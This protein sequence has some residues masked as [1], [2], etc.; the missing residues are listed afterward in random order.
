MTES[1][2]TQAIA[3]NTAKVNALIA[4]N[5]ELDALITN[6]S[7][8]AMEWRNQANSLNNCKGKIGNKKTEC[9]NDL[10]HKLQKANA[11]TELAKSREAEKALN[12]QEIKKLNADINLLQAARDTAV[13]SSKEVS[14]ILANQ[15]LTKAGEEAKAEATAEAIKNEA[16]TVATARA[17]AITKEGEATAESKKVQGWIFAAAGGVVLIILSIVLIKKFKKK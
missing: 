4:R 8:V 14:L 6:Y 2:Y 12:L 15:G 10:T 13:A 7:N 3:D 9:Q 1:Q 16:Q 5:R 11:N 17:E